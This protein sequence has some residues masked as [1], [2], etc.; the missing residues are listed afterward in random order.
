MFQK[1]DEGRISRKEAVSICEKLQHIMGKLQH[2]GYLSQYEMDRIDHVC[3]LGNIEIP[4]HETLVGMDRNGDLIRLVGGKHRLAISQQIGIKK[5][6]A[7]L[8]IYH[9]NALDKLPKAKRL[10]KGEPEDFAPLS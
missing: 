8:S 5:M 1:V 10:I 7:I 2:K 3:K 4:Q 6:P 9:K